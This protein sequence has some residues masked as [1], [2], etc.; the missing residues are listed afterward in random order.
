M[1]LAEA[2]MLAVKL[3]EDLERR[4]E[5]LAQQ[6]G[7]SKNAFV[8]EAVVEHIDELEDVYL[9]EQ[10]HATEG[11]P[12]ERVP[13]ADLLKRYADDLGPEGQ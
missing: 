9:A 4:L 10:R 1:P 12:G 5:Q 2:A 7:R 3:P 8:E 13:L 6:T 11:D